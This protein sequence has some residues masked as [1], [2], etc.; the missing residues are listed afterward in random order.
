MPGTRSGLAVRNSC[1]RPHGW[2]AIGDDERLELLD[3]LGTADL[4]EG[5]GH[6]DV[7]ELPIGVQ[8]QQET[9]EQGP[10]RGAVLVLAVA[11]DHDVGGP[12]V[13]DLHHHAAVL[14]VLRTDRLG[15]HAV[16]PGTLELLEPALGLRGVGGRAGQV[17]G[18][19]AIQV[20]Q[21]E[22]SMPVPEISPSPCSAWTSPI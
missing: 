11:G 1:H 19:A 20:R 7:L 16:E 5:R 4:G 2:S 21:R 8:A 17:A 6:A 18:P 10:F 9:A 13:L 14:R 3:Q 22:I 15:H 12:G